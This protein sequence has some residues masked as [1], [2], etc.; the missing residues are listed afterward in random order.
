[1]Y[2]QR[3]ISDTLTTFKG[4]N[5][6]CKI[7]KKSTHRYRAYVG[8][9]GNIGD[10]KR[11]LHHLVEY[12]KKEKRVTLLQSSTILKN[13][14]FGYI[15][16]AD[17][18]NAVFVF[19]V[20]MSALRFLEYLMRV[21]KRFGRKRSFANAPRTLD[22]DI[23]FFNN[24]VINKPKLQVPHPSWSERESVVIPLSELKI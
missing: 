1:M 23:L 5:F 11:R 15:N 13:P 14:P 24:E 3:K 10:V 4:P 8:V 2:L 6:G 22:L 7:E 20:S 19:Q 12:F 17:F 9:G 16:Q 21:E 18:F